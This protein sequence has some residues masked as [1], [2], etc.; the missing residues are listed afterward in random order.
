M[1]PG[2]FVISVHQK[3]RVLEVKYPERP[4]LPAYGKYDVEVRAAI[5]ALA[6]GGPW[7]CIVDQTALRAMAPE[8]PPLIAVLNAW[9]REHGMRRTARLV[10]DSAI[11]ELQTLRIL[12][13][14]GVTN[15]GQVFHDRPSAWAFVTTK[16]T[17]K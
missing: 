2:P 15:M 13:D 11:G 12:R 9:A 6:A 7:D 16:L 10:S 1:T 8:F 17:P 14:A 4:T 3:E 5:I